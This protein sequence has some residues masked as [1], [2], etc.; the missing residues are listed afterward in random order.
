MMK[1]LAMTLRP[2]EPV[3][4]ILPSNDITSVYSLYGPDYQHIKNAT[5]PKDG[6]FAFHIPESSNMSIELSRAFPKGIPGGFPFVCVFRPS[7]LG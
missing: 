1:V 4:M 7:Q 2:L 5:D 3:A 6:Q